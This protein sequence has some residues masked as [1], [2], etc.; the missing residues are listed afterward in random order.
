MHNYITQNHYL[1]LTRRWALT[2]RMK[3]AF[4]TVYEAKLRMMTSQTY[5]SLSPDPMGE[6]VSELVWLLRLWYWD[7]W[8]TSSLDGM[9]SF[10]ATAPVLFL[11]HVT[12]TLTSVSTDEINKTEQFI[13]NFVPAINEW[14]KWDPEDKSPLSRGMMVKFGR[15]TEKL[16]H[17]TLIQH[18]MVNKL[19][20][21]YYN[22]LW[23]N[24]GGEKR[25][26]WYRDSDNTG[27]L[28]SIRCAKGTKDKV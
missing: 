15:G 28:S 19:T 1:L 12:L 2:L 20:L 8:M 22:N 18:K 14:L 11:F 23:W 3:E 4:S 24:G 10:A 17:L 21:Y 7:A 27:V 26:L 13:T 5:E 16:V 9:L 6:N 25:Y